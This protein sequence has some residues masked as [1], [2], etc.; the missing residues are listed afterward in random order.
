M[1]I[2]V[3][4][5]P[6]F[7]RN[8]G[9]YAPISSEVNNGIAVCFIGPAELQNTCQNAIKPETKNV[10]FVHINVHNLTKRTLLTQYLHHLA[11]KEINLNH[12]MKTTNSNGLIKE[13]Q[14]RFPDSLSFG[15]FW[16]YRFN[17]SFP[18]QGMLSKPGNHNATAI[19][20][21]TKGKIDLTCNF[22]SIELC[23][24]M[25]FVS[26]PHDMLNITGVEN[27][28][29]YIIATEE[30]TLTDYTIDPRYLPELLDKF[31]DMPYV[32]L[33]SKECSRICKAID[34]LSEYIR[35]KSESPFKNSI[36][37]S[38]MSTFAYVLADILYEHAPS[39][40][41]ELRTVKREKEHFNTF[42]RLL[43]ENHTKEREVRFYADKMSLTPRYLT[44]TIRKVSGYTVSE[45][46]Y[47]FIIKD[48]KYLLKHT[49]MTVQQVAYELN[50]PNQ[51]FFG[52]FFKKHTGMSPGSY[53]N[54][55]EE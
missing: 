9:E 18:H 17:L 12:L 14:T 19:I 5:Y 34:M 25:I 52:K 40:E 26:R 7:P 47:R 23:E 43:T 30:S 32:T 53:R 15:K 11:L 55:S 49:D 51:S 3:S 39:I 54:S 20:I 8:I 31:S 36:I 45:W 13:L 46:I 35:H 44:T 29:G 38:G 4:G 37:N 10:P 24:N 2:R 1:S 6:I 41:Y 16:L 48:A 21:C 28:E 22:R 27:C 33:E 42:I 50:F